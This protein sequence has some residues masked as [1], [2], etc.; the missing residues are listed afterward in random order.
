[1]DMEQ[2][3]IECCPRCGTNGVSV[4]L[5]MIGVAVGKEPWTEQFGICRICNQGV[6][7]RFVAHIPGG[8]PLRYAYLGADRDI[9]RH[10]QHILPKA[11]RDIPEHLPEHAE[12]YF[13]QG[14]DSLRQKNFDAA[15]AMFRKTLESGL[16]SLFGHSGAPLYKLI[17]RAAQE[18]RLTHDLEAWA[19]EIRISGNSAVHDDKPFSEEETVQLEEFTRLVM[20]YLFT[21]P[22]KLSLAKERRGTRIELADQK[23]RGTAIGISRLPA[24]VRRS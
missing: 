13:K 8:N 24:A 19:N 6:I 22:K 10:H 9:E 5:P 1:M 7:I 12:Q 15:G 17:E 20:T 4:G 14:I 18:G 16:K 21:L 3:P 2:V 23:T 11:D